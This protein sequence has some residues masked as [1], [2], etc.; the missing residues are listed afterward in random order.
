MQFTEC[1]LEMQ[2]KSRVIFEVV[3]EENGEIITREEII[4]VPVERPKTIDQIGLDIT[5]Q[6]QLIQSTA[7]MIIS[8]QGPLINTHKN[9]PKCQRKVIKK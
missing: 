2:L 7:D 6:Q 4:N 9:C 1:G 5:L 8:L 3:N